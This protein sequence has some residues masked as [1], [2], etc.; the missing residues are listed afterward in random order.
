MEPRLKTNVVG[1][2]IYILLQFCYCVTLSKIIK[3]C[4]GSTK[5]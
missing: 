4:T 1:N 3:I 5:R 2:E